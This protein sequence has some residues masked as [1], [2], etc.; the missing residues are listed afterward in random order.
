M[1]PTLPIRTFDRKDEFANVQRS[2]LPHWTQ[3]G[4]LS[5]ITFRTWDSLPRPVLH[6]WLKDRNAWLRDHQIEPLGSGW[7]NA[8]DNLPPRQR[9]EFHSFMSDRWEA[10]LDHCHGECVLRQPALS[11][12]V[13][14]SFLH[15]D[16]QRSVL[17]DFVVMPNHVHILAA[18]PNEDAML[19]QCHP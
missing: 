11:T 17:T 2:G 7:R 10:H 9:E 13:S 12:I 4:C 15:F 1:P 8:I 5:F 16:E 18:F 6:K 3:A 14:T 19:A